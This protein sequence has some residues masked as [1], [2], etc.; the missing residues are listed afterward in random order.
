MSWKLFGYALALS[1]LALFALSYLVWRHNRPN[2]YHRFVQRSSRRALEQMQ[3]MSAPAV[4][5]YMRTMKASCDPYL[6]GRGEWC[7]PSNWLTPRCR[8]SM[9]LRSSRRSAPS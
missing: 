4:I 6:S 3:P 8:G 2:S 1:G 5:S 7:L 9:F